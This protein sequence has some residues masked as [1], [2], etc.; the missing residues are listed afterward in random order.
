MGKITVTVPV[1]KI[2]ITF[3]LWLFLRYKK[4]RYGYDLRFIPLNNGRYAIVDSAD[5]EKINK[6]KWGVKISTNTTYAVRMVNGK[7]VYM[8]NQIMQPPPG[9]VVDHRDRNGL[10]NGR[11][12][13]RLATKA[14]N[15]C[16]HLKRPGCKSKCR[17]V[18]YDKDLKKWRARIG[19]NNVR[20]LLGYFDS[21]ADAAKAYDNA[22][23]KL[24]GDFAILN[25][26]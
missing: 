7:N 3:S 16:N 2:I 19:F 1:P 4:I 5:F 13:L 11:H 24:H 14:Q 12:N 21:E 25:F 23:R 26:G 17:G 6:N 10:N 18:D 20:I 15:C 8:H 22:A 9:Y